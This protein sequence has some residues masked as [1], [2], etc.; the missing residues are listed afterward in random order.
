[1]TVSNKV[2]CSVCNARPSHCKGL[3][4]SC[5]MRR[6]R[7][8]I[9]SA[10]RKAV[11]PE[12]KIKAQKDDLLK[13]IEKATHFMNLTVG[14]AGRMRWKRKIRLLKEQLDSGTTR[15]GD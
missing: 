6:R 11:N 4:P 10:P 7:G 5:Y 14:V 1:M 12:T 3:C 8:L 13:E 9:G 15:Q 2:V